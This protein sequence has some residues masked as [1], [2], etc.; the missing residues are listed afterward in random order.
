[1]FVIDSHVHLSLIFAGKVKS[2]PIALK[3][4]HMFNNFISSKLSNN[5]HTLNGIYCTKRLIVSFRSSLIRDYYFKLY[6]TLQLFTSL[7]RLNTNIFTSI[8]VIKNTCTH[9]CTSTKVIENTQA[10]SAKANGKELKSCLG[11]VFN[12]KLSFVMGKVEWPIQVWPSPEWKTQPRL[13]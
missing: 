9:I 11:R 8:K 7:F 2:L 13:A 10:G 6:Y 4:F 3:T 5:E 1:V 12:F